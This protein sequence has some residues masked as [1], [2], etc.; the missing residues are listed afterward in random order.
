MHPN[1]S[2]PPQIS[3]A[4]R[5]TRTATGVALALGLATGGGITAQADEDP[6]K[7]GILHSLSGT[8]AISETSLRDVALMT[9][10]DINENGGLLGRELEPVV[11]DPGSDWPTYAEHAR[12]MIEREN[13]DVIFGSWTSVSREAVLPVLEE[14]NGLMFYPVQYEG[15]ESSRNIFYTGA[16]PNQQ[17]LPGVEYLMSDEGGGAERFFLVGTDYVFPRTTNRIVRAYLNAHGISDDAIEEVYFP[18]EHA[19][20]QTLVSDIDSF[21]Q[22]GPTA[23]INTINGDSNVAFYQEL[24][25]QGIDPIDVPVLAT[26]VG[27]EELRGMDTDPLAGHLAAWNYFMS[28]ETPENERFT[29]RWME[30]VEQEGLSGGSDRVTNDPME[31]TH[32]GMRMWAQAVLQAGTTDVDAVR[33]AVYGQCVDAPSG[34]EVCMDDENHHLHKPVIIGEIQPD[35]QFFPVWETDDVVR[36]EPWSDYVEGNEDRVANWRYPWVCGDC[37]EPTYDLRF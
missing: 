26:S 32:I 29:E 36:A 34:F 14:L 31:A 9:I 10:E 2:H 18:F 11:M 8:M 4:R 23:V 12:E 17:T 27:E 7:V 35:G 37:E 22:D 16:A 13:V 20:F 33:Q 30:Y 28:I 24:A 1:T 25:N 6:I 21:S 15:E 3:L 19:D 5:A